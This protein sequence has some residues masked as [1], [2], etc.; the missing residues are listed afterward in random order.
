MTIP[1]ISVD[2]VDAIHHDFEGIFTCDLW[3][4]IRQAVIA[5]SFEALVILISLPVGSI[6]A[7]QFTA[8]STNDCYRNGQ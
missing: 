3:A 5:S 4:A 6:P 1:A 2:N 8:S 7:Y